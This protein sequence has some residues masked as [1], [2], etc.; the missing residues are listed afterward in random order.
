MA[1]TNRE[2]VALVCK[3]CKSQNYISSRNKVN[4]EEKLAIKKFCK[5]CKKHIE[6]KES[7]KLK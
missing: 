1:K 3:N 7:S 2:L 6:H 4:M 5:K